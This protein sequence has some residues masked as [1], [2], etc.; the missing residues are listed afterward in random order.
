MI[1]LVTVHNYKIFQALWNAV[2]VQYGKFNGLC[3][4]GHCL[5]RE[6]T[7]MCDMKNKKCLCGD[8]K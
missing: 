2:L 7:F 4:A 1:W 3:L 5:S 6:V 8:F